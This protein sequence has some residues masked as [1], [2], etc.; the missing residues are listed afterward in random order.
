MRSGHA[1][2][3]TGSIWLEVLVA[4]AAMAFISLAGLRTVHA[5]MESQVSSGSQQVRMLDL[6][7]LED[8]F[9]RAWDQR[10]AH[11][12]QETAWLTIEG[13]PSGASIDLGALRMRSYAEDGAVV[14]WE[15]RRENGHWVIWDGEA[16]A[17]TPGRVRTLQYTGDIWLELDRMTWMPGEVPARV[18]WRFPDAPTALLQD[19]FA[20]LRV[21]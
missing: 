19:G 2:A 9:A 20:I 21:W 4:L 14:D 5:F 6:K 8:A 11:P 7:G 3:R 16:A 18:G 10:C 15:L 12:Y 1:A 13:I 17:E